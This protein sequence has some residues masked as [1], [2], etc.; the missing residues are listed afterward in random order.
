MTTASAPVEP[1]PY[2]PHA[3]PPGRYATGQIVA[4]WTVVGLVVFQYLTGGGMEAAYNYALDFGVLPP[5]GHMWVHG[6]IGTSIFAAMVWRL[7]L[8]LRLG[9][10]KPPETEPTVLQ[11]IS[12]SVHYAFYAILLAMPLFGMAA[13]WLKQGWLGWAHGTAAYVLLG[14]AALHVAGALWHAVKRDGVIH[15]IARGQSYP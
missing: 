3:R 15:R 4:H 1:T 7:I 5:S 14:L 2:T 12:R 6:I 11:W 8:R 13:L 9:A 10:P